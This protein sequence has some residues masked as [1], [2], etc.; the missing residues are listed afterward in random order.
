MAARE[1]TQVQPSDPNAH[2]SLHFVTD[3]VKHP[4]NLA[5]DTLP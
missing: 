4:P 5:I 3:L 1:F 2:E